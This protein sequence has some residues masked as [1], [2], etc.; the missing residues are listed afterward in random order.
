MHNLLPADHKKSLRVLYRARVATVLLL[1]LAAALLV[2]V[3]SLMPA[4]VLL[5]SENAVVSEEHRALEQ[6]IAGNKDTSPAE[7]LRYTGALMALLGARA[8][9]AAASVYLN[10][11][12]HVLPDGVTVSTIRYDR[13]QRTLLLEGYALRR[14]TL[15]S[16][17]RQLEQS[18]LFSAVN[19]PIQ[20]LAPSADLTW[21]LNLVIAARP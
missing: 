2:G 1:V 18:G 21:H 8:E 7:S 10:E 6:L 3:V 9:E 11:A 4:L 5:A 20:D 12:L 13:E 16:F 15:V 14:D 19:L 17:T